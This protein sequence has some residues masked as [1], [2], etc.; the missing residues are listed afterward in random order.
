MIY[1]HDDFPQG[2]NNGFE[3]ETF[4]QEFVKRNKVHTL[5]ILFKLLNKDSWLVR[6]VNNTSNFD[7]QLHGWE[8][9]NYSLESEK[10]IRDHIVKSFRKSAELFGILPTVWYLPWN[11]WVDGKKFE[12]V[13]RVTKIA[14]D[15]GLEVNINCEH[16][17][18]VME[19]NKKSDTV[20]FH[21]WKDKE[22]ILVS[23]LLDKE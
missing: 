13:P 19:K 4:H 15:Y 8:H 3:F 6:Y 2:I 22:R 11:G 14:K 1:R 17:Y 5:S 18:D 23:K 7:I 16:I 21:Y 20:Y 9:L 12:L 10:V